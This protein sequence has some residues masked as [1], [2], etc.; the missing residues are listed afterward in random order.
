MAKYF[1]VLYF[2]L[3]SI[4]LF[5]Q[6]NEIP[7]IKIYLEDGKSGKNI[8]NAKVT[9]EGFELPA[10]TAKYN[11]KEQNYYFNEIPSGY[12]T[13]MAYHK[14]YN[15]KGFQN[16]TGLPKELKFKL[17][18]PL[19]VLYP[20]DFFDDNLP[21][22]NTYVE[23]PYKISVS[24]NNEMSYTLFKTFITS[25]IKELNL[26]I[27]LVNP[28]WEI[29]K[30]EKYS[31]YSDQ[32]EAYPALT[33]KETDNLGPQHLF[34]LKGGV[35]NFFPD[36]KYSNKPGDICFLLRKKDGSKFKRFNDPVIKK[37]KDEKLKVYAVVLNKK[38]GSDFKNDFKIRDRSNAKFN[39]AHKTDSSRIFFY[40]PYF[41]NHKKSVFGFL[42]NKNLTIIEPEQY[43]E[44]PSFFLLRNDDYEIPRFRFDI[45]NQEGQPIPAQDRSLG[46]GILD[47]YE[48]Y[49]NLDTNKP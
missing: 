23:D 19:N 41:R 7:A 17:F 24:A 47:M 40:N 14:K 30:I 10:L 46:L 48:Y 9:L 42:K 49:L 25:K 44:F 26:E 38:N 39:S 31:F 16:T 11:H 32:K 8:D 1:P 36:R 33:V 4:S 15:E 18:E 22:K 21:Y 29:N 5:A 34:A 20:F 28:Y 13:V 12:T 2:T 37:L 3:L 45:Q 27:E 43:P 35:I 6:E